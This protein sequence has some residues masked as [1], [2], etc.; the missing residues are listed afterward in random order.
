[1]AEERNREAEVIESKL[2]WKLELEEFEKT[3]IK[4]ATYETFLN[5]LNPY[6][7]AGTLLYS[8]YVYAIMDALST[9]RKD[10]LL[11]TEEDRKQFLYEVYDIVWELLMSRVNEETVDEEKVEEGESA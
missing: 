4:D 10:E 1:M 5:R 3:P 2:M 6:I 11:E 8:D 7:E 9:H